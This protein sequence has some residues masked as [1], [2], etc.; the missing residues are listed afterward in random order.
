LVGLKQSLDVFN[1]FFTHSMSANANAT[2][3]KYEAE[4]NTINTQ[5]TA[6]ALVQQQETHLTNDQ[7][8]ILMDLFQTSTPHLITYFN[9]K[10]EDLRCAW[11]AAQLAQVG[12]CA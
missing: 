12:H 8:I 9:I 2:S 4:A 7:A 1:D 6:V 11:L 10:K 3:R 5:N